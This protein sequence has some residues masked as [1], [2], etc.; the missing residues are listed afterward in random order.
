MGLDDLLGLLFLF[1]FIVL[2]ALQGLLRRGQ[3]MPP[4]FEPDEIPLPGEE[5]RPPVQP[6]QAQPTQSSAPARPPT[7]TRPPASSTPPP[8]PLVSQPPQPPRPK[9]PAAQRGKTL[10]EIERERLART[11]SRPA[12]EPARP[13][14]ARSAPPAAKPKAKPSEQWEFSTTP[15][16]ILNGVVWHQVLAEP[17]SKYW[18][19]VR[20]PK[21]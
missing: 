18:R 4:D 12:Q 19:R 1:F 16:A 9:A 10:E 21:R 11:G 20:K 17:R 7:P 13:A 6:R 2:P 5:R 15:R 3:Q 8:R 14:P